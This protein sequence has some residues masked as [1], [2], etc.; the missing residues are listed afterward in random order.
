MA[1]ALDFATPVSGTV[2]EVNAALVDSLE[3]IGQS[4]EGDG[5]IAK[6]DVG[7]GVEK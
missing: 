7:S 3:K 5:W 4:P 1:A 2:T 6:L